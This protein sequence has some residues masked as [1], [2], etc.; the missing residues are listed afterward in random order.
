MNFLTLRDLP[1]AAGSFAAGSRYQ[2]ND[3]AAMLWVHATLTDTALLAYNL[4]LPALTLKQRE[5]YYAENQLFAALF[6]IPYAYL[7]PDWTRVR[8]L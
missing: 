8:S 7:P 2:A 3:I 6:G 5:D 1:A 4:V